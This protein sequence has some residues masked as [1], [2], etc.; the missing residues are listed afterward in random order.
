MTSLVPEPDVFDSITAMSSAITEMIKA[1]ETVQIIYNQRVS[2]LADQVKRRATLAIYEEQLKQSRELFTKISDSR[3]K[4]VFSEIKDIINTSLHS[5]FVDDDIE[6]LLEEIPRGSSRIDLDLHT[7]EN[8]KKRHIKFG[9]GNGVRQVIALLLRIVLNNLYDKSYF[10]GGDEILSGLNASTCRAVTEMLQELHKTN[11]Y[12]F[13][14][15]EQ[16]EALWRYGVAG[17]NVITL[18]KIDGELRVISTYIT[19]DSSGLYVEYEKNQL[20][21]ELID[22]L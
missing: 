15:V 22:N 16:K 9:N 4:V 21:S 7:L 12:Q 17:I 2:D 20:D 14:F 5:I 18:D 8:G 10:I 13:L 1:E 3:N 11:G 6:L 19:N